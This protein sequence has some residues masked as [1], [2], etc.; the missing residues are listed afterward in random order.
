MLSP[1][2]RAPPV[3]SCPSGTCSPIRFRAQPAVIVADRIQVDRQHCSGLRL[4]HCHST[5]LVLVYPLTDAL[6]RIFSV[7][8]NLTG[9]GRNKALNAGVRAA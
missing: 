1:E 9:D 8:M 5:L 4:F 2:C 6:S 3:T 7:D